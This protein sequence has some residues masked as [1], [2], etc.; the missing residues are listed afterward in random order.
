MSEILCLLKNM[1][2]KICMPS[3]VLCEFRVKGSGHYTA[4]LYCYN[5]ENRG[6]FM[7]MIDICNGDISKSP[8]VG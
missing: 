3:V 2:K 8:F 7:Y 6:K 1:F 4:L 5:P